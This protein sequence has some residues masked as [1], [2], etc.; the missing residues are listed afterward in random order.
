MTVVNDVSK[1]INTDVI[2][3]GIQSKLG[4]LIKFAP[5]ADIDYTLVS[6]P[7]TTVV[8][9]TWSYIGDAVVVAEGGTVSRDD[10]KATSKSFPVLKAVKDIVMTDESI[11]A[12]NAAVVGEAESQ[13]GVSIS[14]K[15]DV[16]LLGALKA[17]KTNV[18]PN[19]PSIATQ[20]AEISQKGL[21]LLRVAF[22]E[23]IE[24]AVLLVSPADYGE[25]LSMKEFVAVQQGAPF[26]AGTVGHVMGLNIVVTGRLTKGEA[27]LV[28]AGALGLSLKR[29][30][31]VQTENLMEKRSQVVGAD[32]HYVAYVKNAEKARAVTLTVPAPPP[33]GN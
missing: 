13:L 20:A 8:F 33:T 5:L 4:K 23:D 24:D 26:M 3:V 17:A 30:V 7:G 9:P 11:L 32:I 21:A 19:K 10:I 29:Q 31:F 22:G 1:S 18:D 12:T 28:K 2:A 15:V 14:N 6:N 16:D 25:I 27:F